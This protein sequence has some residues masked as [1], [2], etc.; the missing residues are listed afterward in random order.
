MEKDA[1]SIP[2]NAMVAPVMAVRRRP[3]RSARTLET[4]QRRKVHPMAREPTIEALK[5]THTDRGITK[6]GREDRFVFGLTIFARWSQPKSDN[7]N[8]VTSL[9]GGRVSL[10]LLDVDLFE[11]AEDDSVRVDDAE[12]DPVAEKAGHHHH[13]GLARIVHRNIALFSK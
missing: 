6:V 10:S 5:H 11:T 4:G 7:I 2:A 12:D 1:P 9:L 3:K 13:P 8:S